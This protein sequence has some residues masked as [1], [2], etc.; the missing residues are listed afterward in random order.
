ME[1]GVLL[2]VLGVLGI[3]VSRVVVFV[4]MMTVGVVVLVS[5]IEDV[6]SEGLEEDAKLEDVFEAVT[7]SVGVVPIV[8]TAVELDLYVEVIVTG[9]SSVTMTGQFVRCDAGGRE[10]VKLLEWVFVSDGAPCYIS[11]RSSSF[12]IG[13]GNKNLRL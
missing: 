11:F 10:D 6:L 13:W 9:L 5:F 3:G 1:S 7:V 4:D 2:I 12:R 8:T